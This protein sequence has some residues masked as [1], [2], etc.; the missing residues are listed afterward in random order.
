MIRMQF[1]VAVATLAVALSLAAC[2]P[3][4]RATPVAAPAPVQGAPAPLQAAI[5]QS[6]ADENAHD[7]AK[8]ASHYAP[9]S[10][11]IILGR[12][13]LA[14]PAAVQ[15]DAA[16]TFA[17]L[18]DLHFDLASQKLDVAASGELAVLRA[19]YT[20][21]GTDPQSKAAVAATGS[22]VAAYRRQ[23][24]GTW[25]IEWSDVAQAPASASQAE[26]AAPARAHRPGPHRRHFG[27][28]FRRR[29]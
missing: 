11:A 27:R 5:D 24:D 3:H 14:G 15:A 29:Y 7:A 20:V 23:A 8:V 22:Y 19:T 18:P 26:T 2:Q 25:K 9:G 4:G 21:S 10:Q 12:P 16:R 1:A 6:V 13:A 17:A 28:H